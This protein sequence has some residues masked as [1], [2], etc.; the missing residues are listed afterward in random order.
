M[1]EAL[2][3]E[4]DQSNNRRFS[5]KEKSEELIK[6]VDSS[7]LCPEMRGKMSLLQCNYRENEIRLSDCEL[8]ADHRAV[9]SRMCFNCWHKSVASSILAGYTRAYALI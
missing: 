6:S 7:K 1:A 3:E 8:R 2:E 9:I 4:R 5:P